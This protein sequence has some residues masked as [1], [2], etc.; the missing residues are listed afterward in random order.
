MRFVC[1]A[2]SLVTIFLCA[3][4]GFTPR[5]VAEPNSITLR[6]AVMD[7]ADSL[8]AVRRK[9][10][11]QPKI[12]MYPSEA[13]VTF[14]ISASSSEE[15]GLNVG[16]TVPE[17]VSNSPLSITGNEKLTSN[18]T[19]GNQITIKFLNVGNKPIMK[20][21]ASATSNAKCKA[22]NPS[23]ECKKAPAPEN[24]KPRPGNEGPGPIFRPQ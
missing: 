17:A 8:H 15:T 2:L 24:P 18:A 21:E 5:E 4:C 6:S 1:V 14:N 13:T 7:V 11:S 9:Y 12:G 20:K 3:G 10:E 23:D 16:L 19:R 22:T